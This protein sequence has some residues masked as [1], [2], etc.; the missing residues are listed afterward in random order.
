M[1]QLQPG[2]GDTEHR[3]KEAGH[4][5]E[6]VTVTAGGEALNTGVRRRSQLVDLITK[7][8]E[9]GF[10]ANDLRAFAN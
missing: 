7:K 5:Y 3:G 4:N 6:Y 9:I 2:G 10:P 1:S 8:T